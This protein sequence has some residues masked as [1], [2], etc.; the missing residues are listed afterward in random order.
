MEV[1]IMI[2]QLL[3]GISIL[4]GLHEAGHMLTAKFFGMRVEKFFIGFPP[5]VFGKTIG[6]TEYGIGA[7]PMGGFVKIS[8]M[9]DESLDTSTLSAEPE[10]YEFRAKP[11]Y[12]RLI[13]MLGGII[14]NII[15]G[16]VVFAMLVYSNGERYL[17]ASEA[18][19]GIVA[20]KLAQEIGLKDGDKITAVNDKPI[21]RFYDV[22]NPDALLGNNATYTIN[23][24]GEVLKIAIPN[25]LAEKLS[26]PEYKNQEFIAPARP[27]E[28]GA[29]RGGFPAA[30]A[31][32]L[33]GDNITAVN[34]VQTPFFHILQRELEANKGKEVKLSIERAGNNLTLNA[35]VTSDGKLGFTPELLLK[36]ATIQYGFFESFPKGVVM[37]YDIF[38]MQIKGF[39]KIFKGEVSA[40]NSFQGPIAMAQDLY[41]G[42][43]DWGNFWR[44]TGLISLALAFFNLLPIPAL[45]GGHAMFLLYEMVSGRKPSDR[46]MEGAQKVGMALLLSLMVFVIF[47]DIFKRLF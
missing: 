45:D 16:I 15:T 47:N 21:D 2:A 5:K 28:V 37:A 39:G 24:N 29:L 33:K 6:E 9:V 1:V 44:I 20:G 14:V 26:A 35:T 43:W 4:V 27:F 31:G 40:S 11:A 19:F 12:Q 41:G 42:I 3:L 36:E 7:I 17:P 34:G 38:S 22:L 32:V 18:K 30:K 25:D 13:V 46:F 8:G 10:P 23:R